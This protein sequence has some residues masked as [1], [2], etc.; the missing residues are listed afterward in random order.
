VKIVRFRSAFTRASGGVFS[1][2]VATSAALAE[3]H[4]VVIAARTIDAAD[5]ASVEGRARA[6]IRLLPPTLPRARR[7]VDAAIRDADWVTLE[8]AW[9]P[10]GVLVARACRRRGIPYV[11]VPHGS[12][13]AFVRDRY[14]RKH[15][16]KLA[17]WL[18]VERQVVRGAERVW[19]TSAYEKDVSATTFPGTPVHDPVVELMTEDLGARPDHPPRDAAASEC[20]LL[21]MSRMHEMKRLDVLIEALPL[22]A[23]GPENA[24]VSAAIMGDGPA[25][26]LARHQE[27]ARHHGVEDRITWLGGRWGADRVAELADADIFV[28]PGTESFGMSI[29]EALSANL[30][31]VASSQ[32][33]LGPAIEAAGAGALFTYGDPASLAAAVADVRQALQA[34][35]VGTAP[36]ELWERRF[37][38][39]AFRERAAATGLFEDRC[40]RP[41]L[42]PGVTPPGRMPT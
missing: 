11:F 5:R 38:A 9:D 34:G 18:A 23:G 40:A 15:A 25:H 6:E 16:K 37:S 20:R 10:L 12:L 4:E 27:R 31:V 42:P 13:D 29:A 39:S 1:S 28:S 7:E 2:I 21:L 35:V 24:P 26:L 8:G 3:T 36:R 22:L 32:V 41:A 14:R 33:A 19:W 30:P 17:W